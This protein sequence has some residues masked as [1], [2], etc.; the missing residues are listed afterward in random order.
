M[1]CVPRATL[2]AAAPSLRL[3]D[4]RAIVLPPIELSSRIVKR[5]SS[6]GSQTR[7]E[8]SEDSIPLPKERRDGL[9]RD[10]SHDRLRAAASSPSIRAIAALHSLCRLPPAERYTADQSWRRPA[11][12]TWSATRSPRTT[13]SNSPDLERSRTDEPVR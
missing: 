5:W 10:R 3:R 11:D 2:L 12:S 13:L 1:D 6:L 4:L 8:I 9:A 7:P